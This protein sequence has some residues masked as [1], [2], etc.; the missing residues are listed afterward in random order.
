MALGQR[1]SATLDLEQLTSQAFRNQYLT[2]RERL[3]FIN[4]GR[5]A[6]KAGQRGE[7]R[8]ALKVTLRQPGIKRQANQ[9]G[10]RPLIVDYRNFNINPF[11]TYPTKAHTHTHTHTHLGNNNF[12]RSVLVERK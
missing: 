3:A 2:L 6:D 11:N 5:K 12:F 10:I 7:R 4:T 1:A 9:M 8:A